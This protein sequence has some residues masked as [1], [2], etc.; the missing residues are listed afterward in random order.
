MNKKQLAALGGLGAALVGVTLLT[1]TLIN[2]PA[3][4]PES[5]SAPTTVF[6]A[7]ARTARPTPVVTATGTIAPTPTTEGL[8]I[9]DED[10]VT[11]LDCEQA[12]LTPV[13]TIP[14]AALTPVPAPST[15]VAMVARVCNLND[16]PVTVRW[17]TRAEVDGFGFAFLANNSCL[18]N[19]VPTWPSWE[20]ATVQY[21]NGCTGGPAGVGR[22]QELD[23]TREVV[24]YPF[25]QGSPDI[26][27]G[28]RFSLYAVAGATL[29][30]P[31]TGE[32]QWDIRPV[33]GAN[34]GSPATPTRDASRDPWITEILARP[35]G[36]TCGD[37][38]LRG[39]CG[40]NDQFVEMGVPSAMSLA[41]YR[42]DVLDG[43]EV[44]C[45]YTIADDNYTEPL[46]AFWQDM[47]DV[48]GA[49]T[50][51][52]TPTATPTPYAGCQ[53]LSD[54]DVPRLIAG[55]GSQTYDQWDFTP[56]LLGTTTS[57]TL[58]LT[59]TGDIGWFDYWIMNPTY[60][61]TFVPESI[62]GDGADEFLFDWDG[63]WA[64]CE[65]PEH[66]RCED[67][68]GLVIDSVSTTALNDLAGT[69]GW[70]GGP[71]AP[72]PD[73]FELGDTAEGQW[74]L[75]YGNVGGGGD[76]TIVAAEIE[77]CSESDSPPTP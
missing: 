69:E 7:P 65:D 18:N 45:T 2:A 74:T 12:A 27:A 41:G 11:G 16:Y 25:V 50:P 47:M 10:T 68:S 1:S 5:D 9:W 62:G 20:S 70:T 61:G 52:P 8:W 64:Y 21:N 66:H 58:T 40:N 43:A 73:A 48:P 30:C 71:Y 24:L 4:L 56:S 76:M 67:V 17:R 13:A 72:Y 31:G 32:I 57:I 19:C 77:I 34:P 22:M 23:E 60:S 6:T 26:N 55:G 46:K 33:W 29:G 15:P 36:A 59:A 14:W 44:V 37:W 38:N 49:T 75:W 35:Q 51:T 63:L 53:T 54:P 39:G 28:Y 3:P 42:L